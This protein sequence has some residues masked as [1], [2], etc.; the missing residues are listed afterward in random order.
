MDIDASVLR[1]ILRLS[2]RRE[3][4]DEEALLLRAGG[5]AGQVRAAVRRLATAGLVDIPAGRPPRLTME[6]LAV[7]VALLPGSVHAVKRAPRATRAA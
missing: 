7:A 6:G 4:A 5:N 2:R 1:A 3:A